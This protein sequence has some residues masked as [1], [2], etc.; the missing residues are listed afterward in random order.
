MNT[1]TCSQQAD[2]L[3]QGTSIPTCNVCIIDK[4]YSTSETDYPPFRLAAAVEAARNFVQEKFRQRPNDHV[5]FVSFSNEAKVVCPLLH[6]GT[7]IHEILA[8]LEDLVPEFST[9]FCAG[10]KKANQL[11]NPRSNLIDDIL[12]SLGGYF[13]LSRPP[14]DADRHILFLSD[15]DHNHKSKPVKLSARMKKDGIVIDCI[16][17]GSRERINEELLRRIASVGEDGKPRYRYIGDK[18]A[19]LQEFRRIATLRD[20]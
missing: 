16:G 10:L 1:Q 2:R 4:S 13:S 11:F 7:H 17:I 18:N 9:D 20:F 19:L 3:Q 15:G 8:S 12:S 5:A 14:A 6:V